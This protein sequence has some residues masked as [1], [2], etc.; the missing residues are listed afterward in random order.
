ME[1]MCNE[2][3]DTGSTSKEAMGFGVG[4]KSGPRFNPNSLFAS[5]PQRRSSVV[6]DSTGALADE[7]SDSVLLFD[8]PSNLSFPQAELLQ[9]PV[10]KCKTPKDIIADASNLENPNS[11]GTIVNNS[12][13]SEDNLEWDGLFWNPSYV[14]SGQ[15][16][17][18]GTVLNPDKTL[19]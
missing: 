8:V 18:N 6:L 15:T 1:G 17:P 2:N 9:T 5:P 19:H 11:G 13:D 14:E 7:G 4:A 16:L 3:I 12:W 10:L